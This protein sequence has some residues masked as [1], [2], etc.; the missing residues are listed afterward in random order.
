MNIASPQTIAEERS[1]IA[2]HL[3]RSTLWLMWQAVRL[4]V[5]VFLMI[6]EP[7]VR[8]VLGSA[9]LLCMLTAFFLK[10]YGACRV[11]RPASGIRQV[12]CHRVLSIARSRTLS[13]RRSCEDARAALMFRMSSA[14]IRSRSV[15]T[16]GKY[17]AK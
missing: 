14:A 7:V 1:T 16:G 5:L 12:M 9:A 17:L 6:L 11:L 4:P 10:G 8:V 3:F 2:S 13:S 15:S